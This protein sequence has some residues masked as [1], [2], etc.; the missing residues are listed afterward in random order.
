M[1]ELSRLKR[2]VDAGA[3]HQAT[4]G[5]RIGGDFRQNQAAAMFSY[6]KS[7]KEVVSLRTLEGSL[8]ARNRSPLDLASSRLLP[9]INSLHFSLHE[10]AQRYWSAY[11]PRATP[12]MEAG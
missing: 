1:L 10:R 6:S 3:G 7:G 8:T 12:E 11:C 2:C 5:M 9:Q 4:A